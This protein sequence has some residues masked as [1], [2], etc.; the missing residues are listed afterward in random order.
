MT[1]RKA[2][3]KELKATCEQQFTNIDGTFL[4]VKPVNMVSAIQICVECLATEEK[5]GAL[6][7]NVKACY[8]DVFLNIPHVND[9]PKDVT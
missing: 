2:I 5:L 7:E 4:P 6:G 3:A 1:V 9:L 8:A